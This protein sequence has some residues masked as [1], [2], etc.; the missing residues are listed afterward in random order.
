M[1][2]ASIVLRCL[3]I[4]W[5]LVLV[6]RLWIWRNDWVI[7]TILLACMSSLA[8]GVSRQV[9][10][11]M[12]MTET[13]VWSW[14]ELPGFIVSFVL[15][16]GTFA[17]Y[18]L[19]VQSERAEAALS[20]SERKWRSVV[21]HSPDVISLLDERGERTFGNRPLQLQGDNESRGLVRALE[22]V[23][24]TSQ[25]MEYETHAGNEATS[26]WYSHRI[27]PMPGDDTP[28]AFVLI[29]T[30]ITSRKQAEEELR[31]AR[32]ELEQRVAERTEALLTANQQLER[33]M[34]ERRRADIELRQSEAR[35]QSILD[36]TTAVVY[37]K[38]C[39]GHY[40]LIN[41]QFEQLF[42]VSREEFVGKM[43]A[44]LF[45]PETAATFRAND[46]D[47]IE[48]DSSREFDEI[49]PNEEGDRTYLSVKFPL[50]DM[51]GRATAVCG[52]S[53]DITDRKRAEME[54][55]AERKL[56]EQL[57]Q[58]HERDR[59]LTAYE[60]HDGIVPYITGAL[61][62]LE[63]YW[64]NRA[65][66]PETADGEFR[67]ALQL[68]RR[69]VDESRRMIS[70]LRP[71]IIDEQGIA[72]AIQYLISEHEAQG[73]VPVTFDNRASLDRLEPLLEGALYRIAQE[74][75]TN[76][77]RHSKANEAH[78][79]LDT[80]DGYVDLTIEDTGMGF[81]PHSS[82]ENR[83]GLHGIRERANLLRGWARIES[84]PHKGTRVSVR[85]PLHSAERPQMIEI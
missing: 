32:D 22:Q 21:E 65:S 14:E 16:V 69:T 25:S 12:A 59:K 73:G 44:D 26:R 8:Y 83:F 43:D 70:G 13:A 48:S 55:L 63:A 9:P 74:A 24:S 4:L 2:V 39:E 38:D 85:I 1:L 15:L 33:E 7:L 62:Y 31:R 61:M 6:R 49:V 11:W 58:A 40:L 68:L 10:R 54:L 29:S 53:T 47:V 78:L 75:L 3:A 72:A 50:R 82:T 64:E 60:I 71:P 77:R 27:G 45:P 80:H 67:Q 42:H 34:S 81:D 56:L 30:D 41:K 37:V 52:I 18:R 51:Q 17:L 57:L 20:N 66:Q 76:V 79:T 5:C 84:T 23:R 36:N 19:I 35:L 46:L 28:D